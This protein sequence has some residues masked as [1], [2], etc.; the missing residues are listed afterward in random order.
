VQENW[1]HLGEAQIEQMLVG[2]PRA[3]F[4]ASGR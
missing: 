3:T 1:P 2:N 4:E